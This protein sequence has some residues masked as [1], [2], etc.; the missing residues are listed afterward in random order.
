MLEVFEMWLGF[1][2]S[3]NFQISQLPLPHQQE[4]LIYQNLNFP[5]TTLSIWHNVQ[6]CFLPGCAV[7]PVFAFLNLS[8]SDSTR[9]F[10]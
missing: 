9:Q 4:N 1:E 8:V 6:L 5:R 3:L 2:L 10:P 7:S